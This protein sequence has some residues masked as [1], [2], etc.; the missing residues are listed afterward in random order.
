MTNSFTTSRPVEV[1]MNKVAS[2]DGKILDVNTGDLGNA[3]TS[4]TYFNLLLDGFNKFS[5][6]HVITATTLTYEATNDMPNI[7]DSTAV[8]SDI[9]PAVSGDSTVVS[10]TATGSATVGS[11][12][13]WSRMRV[14]RVTTNATNAV[15]L[16]LTRERV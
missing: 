7:D 16:R 3:N 9:T 5:M 6:Q 12:L 15:E 13:S 14:K 8:W 1:S 4:Y 11:P 2:L 10:Y